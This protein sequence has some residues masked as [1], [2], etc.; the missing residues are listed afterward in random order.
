MITF[1][2]TCG[3]AAS[4]KST[5]AHDMALKDSNLLVLDSDVLRE[6]LCNGNW[7]DQSHNDE[8]FAE[9]QKRTIAALQAGHSVVYCATNLSM[10]RRIQLLE[11]LRK[12]FPQYIYECRVFVRTLDTL[13][14][15]NDGREHRVPSYVINRQLRQFQLPVKNEGWDNISYDIEKVSL[16]YWHDIQRR[17]EAFGSQDNPHHTLTLSEHLEAC[18]DLMNSMA[19]H[20]SPNF[21]NL[22]QAADWHDVGKIF[23]RTYDEEGIAHYFG[24]ENIGAQIALLCGVKPYVAQLINYHMVPYEYKALTTWKK[25]FD[26]DMW[27]DLLLL[28]RADE[29]AH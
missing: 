23:T 24:H 17:V 8:V 10:K 11:R 22:L 6:E 7:A 26:E 1:Y 14:A 18:F 19:Y 4:G 2:M 15:Q 5:W 16:D 27:D 12:M 28:H 20:A 3:P 9:M 29:G 21:L 25:R 13:F